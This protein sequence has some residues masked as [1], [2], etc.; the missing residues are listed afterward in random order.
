MQSPA[1]TGEATRWPLSLELHAT[2]S[3]VVLSSL[4]D[5]SPLAPGLIA[6]KMPRCPVSRSAEPTNNNPS[7]TTGEGEQRPLASISHSTLPVAGSYEAILLPPPT[8]SSVRCSFFQ[9]KGV[10]QL[11]PSSRLA[12]HTSSPVFLSRATTNDA[13]SLSH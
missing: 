7:P 2:K 11:D 3:L 9:R 8:T 10:P 4:S 5:M 1:T 13:L 12:R 6:A